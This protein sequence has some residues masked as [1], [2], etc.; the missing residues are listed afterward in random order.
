MDEGEKEL[1]SEARARL[2]NTSGKNAKRKAREKQLQEAQRFD[3]LQKT[4]ELRAAGIDQVY[5]RK[6]KGSSGIDYNAEIPL[7]KKPPL[8]ERRVDKEA[9]LRKHDIARNKIAQRKEDTPTTISYHANKHNV[10]KRSKLNLPAPRIPDHELV[11]IAKIGIHA[12]DLI[13]GVDELSKGNAATCTLLQIMP[14][15]LDTVASSIECV[16]DWGSFR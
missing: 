2:A 13:A 11:A 4:R 16:P 9:R 10:R 7:E 6:R 14:G 12:N 3:S 5:Q 1:F 8:G 15:V